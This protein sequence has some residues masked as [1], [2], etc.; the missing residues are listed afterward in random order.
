[1]E[2]ERRPA[3][4]TKYTIRQYIRGVMGW[5]GKETI[6]KRCDWGAV[7]RR[8]YIRGVMGMEWYGDNIRGLIG[9]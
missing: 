9:V 1:M 4:A 5:S 7:V 6:Y 2:V 8:Q 3:A